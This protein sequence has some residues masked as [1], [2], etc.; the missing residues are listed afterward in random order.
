MKTLLLGLCILLELYF[1]F[2]L[3]LWDIT[4]VGGLGNFE[5]KQKAWDGKQGVGSTITNHDAYNLAGIVN[6][7]GQPLRQVTTDV[8]INQIQ[9]KT[10]SG[11]NF[12]NFKKTFQIMLPILGFLLRILGHWFCGCS[13]NRPFRRFCCHVEEWTSWTLTPPCGVMAAIASKLWCYYFSQPTHP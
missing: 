3:Q 8:S 11:K 7:S 12:P 5:G 1:I 6:S 9:N 4:G 10:S 13:L 2:Y